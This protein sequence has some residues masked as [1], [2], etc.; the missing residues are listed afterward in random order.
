M[1][2]RLELTTRSA[3]QTKKV[4]RVLGKFLRSGDVVALRGELG[5]GKTTLVKGIAK[6]LG[7]PDERAVASP[8]FVLMHEYAGRESV[9]HLDWY[10]LSAVRGADAELAEECFA[11]GVTLIEWPERGRALL[12]RDAWQV[13][14]LH[15]G[16]STRRLS[17]SFPG[18]ADPRLLEALKR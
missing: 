18:G 7:V 9:H 6:G 4:G 17:F 2:A 13:R 8:T 12:P 14:I 15:R 11:E 10:R 3:A 5:A 1:S 16:P